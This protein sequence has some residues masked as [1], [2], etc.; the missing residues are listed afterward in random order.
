M[1]NAHAI[2]VI[3]W[4]SS[5]V[6]GSFVDT[7]AKH[8]M[9]THTTCMQTMILAKPSAPLLSSISSSEIFGSGS[10]RASC[11]MPR[12]VNVNRRLCQ[13]KIEFTANSSLMTDKDFTLD[14]DA[15]FT[16]DFVEAVLSRV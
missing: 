9:I 13:N 2:C 16:S 10:T 4:T 14:Q 11:R 1:I 5:R 8:S 15:S 7:L 6:S 3:V 12:G